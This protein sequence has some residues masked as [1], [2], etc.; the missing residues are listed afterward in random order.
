MLKLALTARWIFTLVLCLVLAAVFA[1]LAQW[2]IERSFLPDSGSNYYTK[3]SY[4]PIEEISKP[5][6]PFTFQE[7]IEQG[8]D[9]VLVRALVRA[10]LDPSQTVLVH[11][12]VQLDGDQGSWLVVP[13]VTETG[14]IFIATGFVRNEADAITALDQART[15]P[16]SVSYVPIDGRYLPTE[17]PLE[18]KDSNS[19]ES[20]SVAQLVNYASG[21]GKVYPGF[22]AVTT[23]NQFTKI[24]GVEPLT[25]GLAKGEGGV[26]WLSL[27]Y[28]IEWIAFA[29]FA[30]FM[31]WRLLADAY[32][33]QQKELLEQTA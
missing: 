33:K 19:F 28:A 31:W 8:K 1:F 5:G 32:K 26:N 2:Q 7:V 15:K 24:K 3:T 18:Q 14:R 21:E 12:R 29:L 9:K 27:F 30:I 13:A 23:E 16:A 4:V 25:I 11:N 6:Q 22:L 20:M 17:A 10:K